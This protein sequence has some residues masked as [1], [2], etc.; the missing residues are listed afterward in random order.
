[1]AGA[2]GDLPTRLA[3]QKTL[4]ALWP[5]IDPKTHPG[6]PATDP[7]VAAFAEAIG[8]PVAARRLWP[9]TAS[10]AVRGRG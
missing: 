8:T 9:Y 3:R 10:G 7:K 5:G 2:G 1:M 6:L 4:A